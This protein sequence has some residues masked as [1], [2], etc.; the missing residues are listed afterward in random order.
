MASFTAPS[1]ILLLVLL[2]Y[3]FNSQCVGRLNDEITGH[4]IGNKL[5]S[6]YFCLL[7]TNMKP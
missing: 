4:C 6:H 1:C 7:M 3:S 5:T 2:L